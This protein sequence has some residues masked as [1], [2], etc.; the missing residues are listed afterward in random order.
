MPTVLTH[1]LVGGSLALVA[2]AALRRPSVAVALAAAAMIPDADVVAFAA[3]IPYA[4][5]LGHRGL[6]HSLPFAAIV[7]AVV[8]VTSLRLEGSARRLRLVLSALVFAAMASHGLLDT[9]TDG[10]LGVGLWLP[11]D[12]A[13]YFAPWRPIAVSPIGVGGLLSD[14]MRAVLFSELAW[15][16]LPLAAF[17]ASVFTLRCR[18]PFPRKP[19]DA[20]ER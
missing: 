1:A 16:G 11:F 15:I 4:D 18:L 6:S 14:R 9:F 2:P 3:G 19:R 7:A 5:P 13:R 17:V 20:E 12:D 10:G 8:A